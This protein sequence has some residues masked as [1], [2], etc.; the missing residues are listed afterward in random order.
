MEIN[1]ETNKNG[2]QLL[3]IAARDKFNKYPL[4][5]R[6]HSDNGRDLEKIITQLNNEL[7]NV[8]KAEKTPFWV[9]RCYNV[10]NN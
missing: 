8:E 5:M 10:Q 9:L 1:I 6:L 3:L 7:C 2:L 4:N